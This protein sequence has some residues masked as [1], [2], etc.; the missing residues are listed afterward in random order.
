M[1]IPACLQ[2]ARVLDLG[3]GSGQDCYVLSQLVGQ[4]G[5][6]T[7]LDMTPQQVCKLM[8]QVLKLDTTY[9]DS[10]PER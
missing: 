1:V 2:S 7:G 10:I 4:D 8:C 6:V 5:L 3:C 9:K